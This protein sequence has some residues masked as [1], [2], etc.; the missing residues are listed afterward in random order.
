MLTTSGKFSASVCP[1][2]HCIGGNHELAGTRDRG[3]F[4]LLAGSGQPSLECSCGLQRKDARSAAAK[5]ARRSR[6]RAGDLTNAG[7]IVAVVI[8]GAMPASAA[9]CSRIIWPIRT[10]PPEQPH[11]VLQPD[12][13]DAVD[14]G[15]LR[16]KIPMLTHCGS[17]RSVRPSRSCPDERC[18]LA[19]AS[20]ATYCGSFRSRS[21]AEQSPL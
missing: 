16:G 19:L 20:R 14:R 13:I 11:G 9:A 3:A 15:A 10:S 17:Q 8:V 21:S 5:S 1:K 4:V 2:R 7:A 12:P 6:S 18:L